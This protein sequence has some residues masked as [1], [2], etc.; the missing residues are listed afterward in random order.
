M[1]KISSIICI[2]IFISCFFISKSYALDKKGCSTF[3]VLCK[4]TGKGA[5][6][7]TKKKTKSKKKKHKYSFLTFLS[8]K[9]ITLT[10]SL[11]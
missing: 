10:F 5:V 3:D 7:P 11:T 4:L 8:Y 9:K 6:D 1:R 2:V